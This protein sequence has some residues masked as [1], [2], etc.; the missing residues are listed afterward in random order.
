SAEVSPVTVN[1][2]DAR[3]RTVSHVV[4]TD[5]PIEHGTEQAGRAG[6]PDPIAQTKAHVRSGAEQPLRRERP[7]AAPV[8]RPSPD[9]FRISGQSAA[10]EMPGTARA[11]MREAR[12]EPV[13][14]DGSRTASIQP[15][16]RDVVLP[17]G[18]VVSSPISMEALTTRGAA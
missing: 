10:D 13:T 6:A 15:P 11:S 9:T 16:R 8:V 17:P 12:A 2:H 3:T 18:A 1:D 5:H 4:S 7:I 14:A